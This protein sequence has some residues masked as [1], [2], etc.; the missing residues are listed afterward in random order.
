MTEPTDY[1]EMADDELHAAILDSRT[2]KEALADPEVRMR[3]ARQDPDIR[4]RLDAM[5]ARAQEA[6]ARAAEAE[7]LGAGPKPSPLP[8]GQYA[9]GG[10]VAPSPDTWLREQVDFLRHGIPPKSGRRQP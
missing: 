10:Y 8:G 2:R 3:L 1:A 9:S 4:A 5:E 7:E 6:E